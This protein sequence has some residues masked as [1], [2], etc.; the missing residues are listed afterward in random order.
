[1]SK[2]VF[3]ISTPFGALHFYDD[4]GEQLGSAVG[5]LID[6]LIGILYG[7]AKHSSLSHMPEGKAFDMMLRLHLELVKEDER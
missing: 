2:F 5:S 6:E 4:I 1:M 3:T 7:Q